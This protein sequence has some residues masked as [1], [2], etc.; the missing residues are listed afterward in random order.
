MKF[1]IPLFLLLAAM[2]V[3]AFDY[4]IAGDKAPVSDG[5]ILYLVTGNDSREVDSTEVSGGKYLF[6]GT[7]A[8]PAY[9]RIGY[10]EKIDG[11]VRTNFIA[12]LIIEPGHTVIDGEKNLP[13]SGGELN[14]RLA[15]MLSASQAL[16]ERAAGQIKA[17][18]KDSLDRETMLRRRKAISREYVAANKAELKKGILANADNAVAESVLSAYAQMCTPDEWQEVYV[19]LSPA[20]KALPFVEQINS[21]HTSAGRASEGTAFIDF[22]ARNPDGSAARFSDYIGKG[23]YVL[24]DF[25]ASWCGP[26]RREARETLMP[27]YE[28]YKDND[29]FT[30][31]GVAVMDKVESTLHILRE[32]GYP[33]P[34]LIDAG[35]TP[36]ELYGFN[37]I[38]MIILFGPDGRIV[39]RGLRGAEI[40]ATVAE[41]LK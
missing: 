32:A 4:A 40:A 11:G 30:I 33:W 1:I 15:S 17:L 3:S 29:R 25:W 7:A 21:R 20:I 28:K 36:A 9:A 34:Q 14:M 6:S 38:P 31:L 18:E 27:L 2:P 13:S 23:R 8:R 19:V 39:A 24:V 41:C 10:K 12:H 22:S 37:A 35:A 5:T 16:Y 26:C